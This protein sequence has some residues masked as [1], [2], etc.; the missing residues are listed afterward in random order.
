MDKGDN[1]P[2]HFLTYV[3]LGLQNLEAGIGKAALKMLQSPPPPPIESILI[4]LLNDVI[5][6]R[7]VF[8]HGLCLR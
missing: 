4:N 6:L 8:P 1:D 7:S 3:I 2:L 5:R